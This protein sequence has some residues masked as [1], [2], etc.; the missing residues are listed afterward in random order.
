MPAEM[1]A[2]VQGPIAAHNLHHNRLLLQGFS[3]DPTAEC[4]LKTEA[5]TMC[6]QHHPAALAVGVLAC[7]HSQTP[8]T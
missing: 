8:Q 1:H 4:S 2:F 6:L 7:E 3:N 5:L